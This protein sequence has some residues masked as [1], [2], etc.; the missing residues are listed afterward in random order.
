MPDYRNQQE[1]TSAL[2]V[3]SWLCL[4]LI[5]V[6]LTAAFLAIMRG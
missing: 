1:D 5:M 6:A 2:K 4:G 3:A